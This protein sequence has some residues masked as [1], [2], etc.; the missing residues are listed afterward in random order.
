MDSVRKQLI[1]LGSVDPSL[2]PHIRKVLAAQEEYDIDTLFTYPDDQ[3]LKRYIHM[4]PDEDWLFHG[5]DGYDKDRVLNITYAF[6]FCN[7]S[8]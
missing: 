3:I 6:S 1:K 4:N 7:P 8:A 5:G 2:R